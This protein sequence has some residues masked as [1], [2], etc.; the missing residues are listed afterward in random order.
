MSTS[1]KATNVAIVSRTETCTYYRKLKPIAKFI[2]MSESRMAVNALYNF[3]D[4]VDLDNIENSSNDFLYNIYDIEELINI[5][6]GDSKEKDKL[7]K[8]SI[9]L[10][11]ERKLVY[12]EIMSLEADQHED[13]E[14]HKVINILLLPLK[15]GTGYYWELLS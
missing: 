12:K 9:I 8:F 1:N 11:L 10:K 4:S 2:R 7:L 13:A 14:F 15:A 5:K 6:F 3:Y